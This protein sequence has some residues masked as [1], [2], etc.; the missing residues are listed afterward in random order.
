M[1]SSA[2]ILGMIALA[3]IMYKLGY[4]QGEADADQF[5]LGEL[6]ERAP[7]LEQLAAE[8]PE[9]HLSLITPIT[10]ESLGRFNHDSR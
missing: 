4:Y 8:R 10:V 2:V 7:V 1:F 3:V 9:V 6:G 5:A